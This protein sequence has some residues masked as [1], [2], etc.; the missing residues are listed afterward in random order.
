MTIKEYSWWTF[1]VL[2]LIVVLF[3]LFLI[4]R[5]LI[6]GAVARISNPGLFI[7]FVGLL[8]A[9]FGLMALC[10]AYVVR[11]MRHKLRANQEASIQ[12]N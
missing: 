9:V 2:F 12:S 10:V 7:Y 5:G 1:Y 6:G 8:M 11:V 4:V 3:L